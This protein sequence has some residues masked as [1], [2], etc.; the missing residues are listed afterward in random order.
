MQSMIVDISDAAKQGL[1][2]FRACQKPICILIVIR[3]DSLEIVAGVDQNVRAAESTV[4][5]RAG[6]LPGYKMVAEERQCN[7]FTGA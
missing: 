7:L 6:K 4:I 5:N 3:I 1:L 2:I